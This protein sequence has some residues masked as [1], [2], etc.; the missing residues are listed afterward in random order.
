ME[1]VYPEQQVPT[2][3][4]LKERDSKNRTISPIVLSTSDKDR[5]GSKRNS[6]SMEGPETKNQQISNF[7]PGEALPLATPPKV[8]N[9]GKN[10]E[11]RHKKKKVDVFNLS[12]KRGKPKR[13]DRAKEIM[14][15]ILE[16]RIFQL[17]VNGFTIYAL[18]G[19]DLKVIFS[20]KSGDVGF[21]VA[22][23]ICI[24]LFTSEIIISIFVRDRYFPH[25]FFLLDLIST[26]TLLFDLSMLNI[27]E[28]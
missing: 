14:Q 26:I 17:L 15:N 6:I 12:S 13:S 21:D 4:K 27:T 1:S 2:P 11:K 5:N 3:T 9:D 24:V 22:T 8:K 7:E 18:F 23:I 19:D 28:L 20:P 16:S 25:F 10:Q